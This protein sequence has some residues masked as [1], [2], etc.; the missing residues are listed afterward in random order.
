MKITWEDYRA[1]YVD[2]DI[3][4]VM[5]E[6][7]DDDDIVDDDDDDDISGP[8]P[9][10]MS[11][12]KLMSAM[13]GPA[14]FG[15]VVNTPW[16]QFSSNNKFAPFNFYEL[17]IMHFNGFS[18][19]TFPNFKATLDSIDGVAVWKDMDP[20]CVIIGKARTYSW[21]TVINNVTEALTK[22][23]APPTP[24][25]IA[26]KIIATQQKEDVSVYV[27]VVF[28]DGRSSIVTPDDTEYM[29]KVQE[30]NEM[31]GTINNLIIIENGVTTC[32]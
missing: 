14:S 2:D 11:L 25:H 13:G 23:P 24:E 9:N 28:P 26:E 19:H 32:N 5:H 15:R 22:V 18:T 27:A 3:D 7:D 29:K 10:G 1:N 21:Q 16:G 8:P 30:I 31:R 17:K 20:Y 6:L 12:G 4:D